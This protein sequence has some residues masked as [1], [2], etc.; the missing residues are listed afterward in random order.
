MKYLFPFV[1]IVSFSSFGQ[2]DSV[3]SK[4]SVAVREIIDQL[5][6]GMRKGDSSVIADVFHEEIRMT[7]TFTDKSGKPVSIEG[8]TEDFKTAV[9]KPHEKVWD[10]RISNVKIQIDDNLAQVW[11]DYSFYIGEDFSHC[12]VNAIQLIKTETGWKMLN[13]I[14]TRRRENCAESTEQD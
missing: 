1:L 13:L 6:D 7:T 8:N 4:D 5:F 3:F 11:M 12:G 10:E 9:G 14:D 2:S